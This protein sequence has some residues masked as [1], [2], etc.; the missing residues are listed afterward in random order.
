MSDQRRPGVQKIGFRTIRPYAM[1]AMRRPSTPLMMIG[2]IS[3][4]LACTQMNMRL[5]I[6]RTAAATTES[7]GCQWKAAGTISPTVQRETGS[8]SCARIDRLKPG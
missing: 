7:A 8:P 3:P 4:Y 1:N 2:L 6:A 5:S